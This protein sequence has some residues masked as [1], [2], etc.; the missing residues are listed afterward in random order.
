MRTGIRSWWKKIK[1]PL[2][3]IGILAASL[4]VFALIVVEVR[5][6]GT[7]FAG[8][9]LFEWLNLLGVLAIPVVVGL[10]TVAI[11]TQ[12]RKAQEKAEQK[13]QY[14]DALQTFIN[15]ITKLI[16]EKD[17]LDA[18]EGSPA[19]TMAQAQ[20][21]MTL[22]WLIDSHGHKAALLQFMHGANLIKNPDP[23]IS[24]SPTFNRERNHNVLNYLTAQWEGI[25]LYGADLHDACLRQIDLRNADLRKVDLS[26]ADLSG[27]DLSGADLSE[28][29]LSGAKV[30]DEQLAKAKSLKGATMPDG[31]IHP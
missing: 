26:E 24:L 6:Y 23:V 8:K 5:L 9:T 4:L 2:S 22:S 17:L 21:T 12:Q 13:Q 20:T 30:T 18:P 31:S 15:T 7:G 28:A 3:V 10:G 19:R 14:K 11:T 27:V 16:L 29:I 1:R 25:N